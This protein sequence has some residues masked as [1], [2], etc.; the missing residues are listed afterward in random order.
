MTSGQG[1]TGGQYGQGDPGQGWNAPPPPPAQYPGYGPA[2][3][4]PTGYGAPAPMERPFAVRAGLGAFIANLILGLIGAAIAFASIDTLVAQALAAENVDVTISDDVLR[5]A[6]IAGYVVALVFA[7]LQAMFIWFAWNGRNWA[8]IVLWVLGGLGVVSG[9]ASLGMATAPS[10]G[11]LTALS[12]FGFAL[13][14]AGI[15]LLAQKPANEWYRYRGWL[16]A[17]G[18]GR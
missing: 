4:A 16:R 14:V 5:T 17:S 7:A 6:V 10:T 2:P 1:G 3:S 13:T 15:V 11:F 12:W 9:L 8:R 18:Q